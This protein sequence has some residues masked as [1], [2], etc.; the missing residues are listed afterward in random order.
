MTDW[1]RH[2]VKPGD[3][4][5]VRPTCDRRA[6]VIEVLPAKEIDAAEELLHRVGHVPERLIKKHPCGTV[7]V[8]YE[9]KGV[10]GGYTDLPARTTLWE[11]EVEPA[12]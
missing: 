5:L 2:E 3:I 6:I 10:Y 1:K 9:D 8:E 7:V 11:Y 4:V 12:E